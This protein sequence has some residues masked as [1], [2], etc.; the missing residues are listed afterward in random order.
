[1]DK[2]SAAVMLSV[3]LIVSA[4]LLIAFKIADLIKRFRRDTEYILSEMNRAE[5]DVGYRYWRRELRCHYLCLIP[6]VTERNVMRLYHRL[7]HRPAKEKKE[8][9]SDGFGHIIA[10]SVIGACICAVCLC[11]VSWAWFSASASTGTATMHSA[12]FAIENVQIAADG[13][14]SAALTTDE[15]GRYTTSSLAPGTYTLSFHAAQDSTSKNGY[16]CITV[17][18]N[19]EAAGTAYYTVN[20]GSDSYT[21]TVKT[22]GAAIVKIEP[23]WGDVNGRISAGTPTLVSGSTITVGNVADSGSN[24]QTPDDTVTAEPTDEPA[25]TTA[26]DRSPT[27]SEPNT[28]ETSAP[29]VSPAQPEESGSTEQTTAPETEAAEETTAA[30]A[31]PIS[32]V[33]NEEDS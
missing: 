24:S 1:M 26:P 3:I 31:E 32:D 25:V 16:C 7:Y 14:A 23:I 8:K 15:N 27:E 17:F 33:S 2:D 6:F 20:I 18:E 30:P 22:A 19:G 21:L 11:G 12:A 4:F 29:T 5:S 28:P 10:P 9:R 13:G